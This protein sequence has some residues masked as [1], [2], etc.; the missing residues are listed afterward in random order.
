MK[1]NL[2][3]VTINLRYQITFAPYYLNMNGRGIIF[4]NKSATSDI[5]KNFEFDLWTNSSLTFWPWKW[6]I[7]TCF[8]TFIYS[9]RNKKTLHFI[10]MMYYC[11]S[12]CLVL[13]L[14][15]S[16]T[17]LYVLVR[18]VLTFRSILVLKQNS[19]PKLLRYVPWG[20]P[21]IICY[22]LDG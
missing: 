1:K 18:L 11:S 19:W 10:G 2:T 6:Y 20:P 16:S 17:V 21:S 7:F 4:G 5:F 22:I 15:N 12:P 3:S 14:W 9:P 13:K 8:S